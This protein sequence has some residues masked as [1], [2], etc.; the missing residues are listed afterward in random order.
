MTLRAGNLAPATSAQGPIRLSNQLT[1]PEITAKMAE[2]RARQQQ[3][4]QHAPASPLVPAHPSAPAGLRELFHRATNLSPLLAKYRY[5][6]ELL[7]RNLLARRYV[8]VYSVTHTHAHFSVKG[9]DNRQYHVNIA[10][11]N[12]TLDGVTFTCTCRT[13]RQNPAT[14]CEH[15]AAAA[16]ALQQDLP[17]KPPAVPAQPGAPTLSPEELEARRWEERLTQVLA[18]KKTV[19]EPKTRSLLLFSLRPRAGNNGWKLTPYTLSTSMFEEAALHERAALQQAIVQLAQQCPIREVS[20]YTQLPANPLYGSP[21]LN[22]LARL[23][24]Q[25]SYQTGNPL[26][27]ALPYLHAALLFRGDGDYYGKAFREP[28]IQVDPAPRLLRLELTHEENGTHLL[29]SLPDGERVIRLEHTDSAIVHF[30]PLWVLAGQPPAARRWRW[31]AAETPAGSAGY[32][33][34]AGGEKNVCHPLSAQTARPHRRSP[35][36]ASGNAKNWR[37]LPCA[38]SI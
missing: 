37:P 20:S 9:L 19:K 3:R 10:N 23:L 31:G 36:M 38:A 33:H 4:V 5:G 22:S 25:P 32:R 29:P 28:I 7:G 27:F 30:D 21:E 16:Y 15:M 17:P 14:R 2:L 26:A 1:M 35:A 6:I 13:V 8:T 12:G 34:S 24:N 11:T 18:G